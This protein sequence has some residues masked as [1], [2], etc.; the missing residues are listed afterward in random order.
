MN[1]H[2]L[3]PLRAA[4]V[5]AVR[6]RA[7]FRQSLLLVLLATAAA[8]VMP[9]RAQPQAEAPAPRTGAPQQPGAV[10]TVRQ[11]PEAC[12]RLEGRYAEPGAADA[13][14]LQVV[15]LGGACQARARFVESAQAR[16]SAASGW[17]LSDVIRIPEARCAGREAEV[18]VWRKGGNAPGARDGQ[19]QA[20]VYLEQ[21]REQAVSA[22]SALPQF[23]AV[24]KAPSGRCG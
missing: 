16:P 21:G 19:G 11:I 2:P 12:V 24:L 15:P 17:T 14:D 1:R 18:Q 13:Y 10:H 4:S 22:A 6:S 5:Q 3:R 9:L 7:A 20:R 23:T 8:V